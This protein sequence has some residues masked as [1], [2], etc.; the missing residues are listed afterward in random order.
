MKSM[1]GFGASDRETELSRMNVHVR[2]VNGRFLEL[3]LHLPK[4][5]LSMESAVRSL[6]SQY[7]TRGTVDLFLTRKTKPTSQHLKLNKQVA[8]EWFEEM[9]A[10]SREFKLDLALDSKSLMAAPG[11]FL[12]EEENQLPEKEKTSAMELLKEA[13]EKAL[14]ERQREGKTVKADIERHLK[15]LLTLQK[16]MT[17]LKKTANAALMERFKDRMKQVEG[18][19]QMDPQRV[20]QEIAFQLE[21]SDIG[22]ELNRLL[23]HAKNC[24][25]LLSKGEEAGKKLDF[26][27]QELLREVNTI[28]SK[29]QIIE[30]T[31]VVIEAKSV[32]DKYREQVQNV[33]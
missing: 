23:E 14:K 11:I 13:L 2:T 24:L 30:L 15:K 19:I 12:L 5:F 20:A 21:K 28:G 17:A 32:I 7:F 33:E 10:L 8:K 6:V 4:E 1:T 3:R 25:S 18:Q 31:Q 27:A 26:Y 16:K 29:S 22:E 9:K